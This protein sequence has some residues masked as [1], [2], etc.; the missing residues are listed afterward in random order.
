M[1]RQSRNYLIVGIVLVVGVV[2]YL[3]FGAGGAL[4]HWMMELHG[5]HS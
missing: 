5:K 1:S 2:C 3:H 4:R